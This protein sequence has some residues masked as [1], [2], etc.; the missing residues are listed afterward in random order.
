MDENKTKL[1]KTHKKF[2][3][4]S[5]FKKK[6]L[7]FCFVLRNEKPKR[8]D[9]K[10]RINCSEIETYLTKGAFVKK[11]FDILILLIILHFLN[12]TNCN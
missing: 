11:Y 10:Q 5:L 4:L 6:T 8:N 1:I 3:Y 2:S 7:K 12:H 9:L